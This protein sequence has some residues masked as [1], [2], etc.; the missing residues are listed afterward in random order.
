MY[1]LICKNIIIEQNI[2]LPV[3]IAHSCHIYCHR[4]I[5]LVSLMDVKSDGKLFRIALYK[6]ETLLNEQD[7]GKEGRTTFSFFFNAEKFP[8]RWFT[9]VIRKNGLLNHGTIT[10]KPSEVH[11]ARLPSCIDYWK[12]EPTSHPK[13]TANGLNVK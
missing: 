9:F 4:F 3:D 10:V 7:K 5:S 13:K 6:I 1:N 12:I 2:L 8:Y 11:L